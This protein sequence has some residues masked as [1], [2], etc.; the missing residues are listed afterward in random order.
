MIKLNQ[1][2][3]I[4]GKISTTLPIIVEGKRD[5]K[6]LEKIGFKNIIPISGKS[7]ERILQFLKKRKY[8]RVAILTDFDKEGRERYKELAR[9]FQKNGIKI[10]SF[11][12]ETFNHTFK[13]HKIEELSSF[14]KLIEDEYYGKNCSTYDKMSVRD[15]FLNRRKKNKIC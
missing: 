8:Q 1:I 11:V 14:T 13:I 6:A 15:K 10:D 7:N 4:R 9:L 12:R 3:H 2:N 5:K